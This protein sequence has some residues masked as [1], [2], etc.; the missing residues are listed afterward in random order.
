MKAECPIGAMTVQR[1][2]VKLAER[3]VY[4]GGGNLFRQLREMGMLNGLHPTLRAEHNGW[5]VETRGY[6]ECG[7]Y[8]RVFITGSGLDEVEARLKQLE[9]EH[10]KGGCNARMETPVKIS[11]YELGV[12]K[13]EF[14]F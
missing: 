8:T 3:G 11:E 2:A 10:N 5:M 9:A 14:G 1:A 4:T 12:S 13:I 7:A 6:W